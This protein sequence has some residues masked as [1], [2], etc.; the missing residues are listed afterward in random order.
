MNGFQIAKIGFA[1]T[2]EWLE[3]ALFGF[4]ASCFS[5]NFFV[6]ENDTVAWIKTFS[7]IFVGFISRPI[8]G[9]FFGFLGDK[10]G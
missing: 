9:L 4:L 2:I 3:F 10:K 5:S 7:L 8:G 1:S 6:S